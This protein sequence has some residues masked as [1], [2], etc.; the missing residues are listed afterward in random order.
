MGILSVG[1]AMSVF[2]WPVQDVPRLPP[3]VSWDRLQPPIILRKMHQMYTLTQPSRWKLLQVVL[4][5]WIA[6][7]YYR[8]VNKFDRLEK[9]KAS[10]IQHV[11]CFSG[12]KRFTSSFIVQIRSV[13]V[14]FKTLP[15]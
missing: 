11:V 15:Y 5:L 6:H 1:V 13:L 8:G 9:P 10:L 12:G 14:F 2:G 7:Y 3:D 4:L